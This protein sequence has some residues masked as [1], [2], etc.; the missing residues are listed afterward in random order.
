MSGSRVNDFLTRAQ[1]IS[2]KA[3]EIKPLRTQSRNISISPLSLKKSSLSPI[4]YQ[5]FSS[6]HDETPPLEPNKLLLSGT[7][8]GKKNNSLGLKEK[9]EKIQQKFHSIK[10]VKEKPQIPVKKKLLLSQINDKDEILKNK[11]N[12][13]NLID[14][15]TNK[16][17]T[18]DKDPQ[19]E[20]VETKNKKKIEKMIEI[21]K[22]EALKMDQKLKVMYEENK[23]LREIL[24]CP[25]LPTSKKGINTVKDVLNCLSRL[26]NTSIH[27]K[28]LENLCVSSRKI[29][30][31]KEI[32]NFIYNWFDCLGVPE[33]EFEN[34]LSSVSLKVL[35]EQQ[36]R[37]KTEE[38]AGKMIE[39]E[40]NLIRELEDKVSNAETLARKSSCRI[41]S[42]YDEKPVL[43]D[44]KIA[45]SNLANLLEKQEYKTDELE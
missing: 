27:D 5:S 41:I 36:K 38:E 10:E 25:Q 33:P 15:D 44:R 45:T 2:I 20:A 18:P 34:F 26:I 19:L 31:T 13:T 32:D 7:F 4:S 11:N 9:L 43:F 1:A 21:F 40:E 22:Q 14:N 12:K 8:N 42:A 24:A 28:T 35:Q 6:T 16:N 23:K 37:L 39:F 29:K 3:S 30:T 17:C